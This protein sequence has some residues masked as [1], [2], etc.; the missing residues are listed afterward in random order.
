MQ[1]QL[2]Q[3]ERML[4]EDD[5]EQEE[6]CVQKY[7]SFA[8]QASDPE[9]QQLFNKLSQEEQHHYDMINQLLQGQQPNMNQS[10]GSSQMSSSQMSSGQM[11][12]SQMGSS[13]MGSSQ[14][15]SSMSQSSSVI[16]GKQGSDNDKLLCTDLL[17]TEKYVSGAYNTGVFEAANPVIRQTLQHIQ[18]EEQ[19][20]GEQLFNYM[21]SHG[22]Y[23]VK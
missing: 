17:S 23:N 12:S 11:G 2:S 14:M 1:M 7:Q 19:K 8:K 20:H 15:S 9:L 16:F 10:S 18:K 3:K 4:L 21:H 5:K 22:M 13:Q 6:L